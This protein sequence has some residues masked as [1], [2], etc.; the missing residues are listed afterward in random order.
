MIEFGAVVCLIL[1]AASMDNLCKDVMLALAREVRSS[2]AHVM[3]RSM[4]LSSLRS[5]SRRAWRSSALRCA[6]CLK[7]LGMGISGGQGGGRV[8]IVVVGVVEVMGGSAANCGSILY[9]LEI[10]M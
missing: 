7:L 9:L 8:A 1:W 6:L 10:E 3:C 5:W 2:S 4:R